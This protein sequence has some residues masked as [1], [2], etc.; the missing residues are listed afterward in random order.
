MDQGAAATRRRGVPAAGLCLSEARPA[1]VHS[2]TKLQPSRTQI[3]E[4]SRKHGAGAYSLLSRH[5]RIVPR[6]GTIVHGL[7]RPKYAV[8]FHSCALRAW[9][10]HGKEWGVIGLL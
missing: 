3:S 7:H 10:W 2:C 1:R 6:R 5:D 4:A 9:L 8:I